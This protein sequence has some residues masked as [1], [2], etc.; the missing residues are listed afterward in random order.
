[1]SPS[2][3]GA[4]YMSPR[5]I[6]ALCLIACVPLS[7]AKGSAEAGQAKSQVCQACHGSDGNGIGDGQYP[8]LAGQ[9]ADYLAKAL[10]DYKSGERVNLIM[11]GFAN[12]LSDQ[13]I[14]DLSAFYASQ[15]GPLTD[16]SHLEE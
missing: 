4:R 2:A 14:K 7:H 3:P 5:L 6:V 11:A 8:R 16:I 1:M 15:K 10:R 13:D 9:Y 12:T